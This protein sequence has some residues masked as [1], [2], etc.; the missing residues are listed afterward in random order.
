MV[1][2]RKLA[3][4]AVSRHHRVGN[5]SEEVGGEIS[6]CVGRVGWTVGGLVFTDRRR[7]EDKDSG[8]R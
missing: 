5:R 1:Y 8:F 3:H 2:G 7:R 6:R 4:V